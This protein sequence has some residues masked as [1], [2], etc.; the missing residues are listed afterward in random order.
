MLKERNVV[1]QNNQHNLLAMTPVPEVPAEG[2][3]ESALVVT[4]AQLSHGEV[5]RQIQV[6]TEFAG[7]GARLFFRSM[8]ENLRAIGDTMEAGFQMEA[9]RRQEGLLMEIENEV[10]SLAAR[11]ASSQSITQRF[12]IE[13]SIEMCRQRLIGVYRQVAPGMT[14][15]ETATA[16]GRMIGAILGRKQAELSEQEEAAMLLDLYR[17]GKLYVRGD[18]GQRGFQR[19]VLDQ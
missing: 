8:E 13:Q 7:L 2:H 15:E 16:V 1:R 3:G 17:A 6:G 5:R 19:L 4:P 11:L 9:L 18:N 10:L 12:V 14:V